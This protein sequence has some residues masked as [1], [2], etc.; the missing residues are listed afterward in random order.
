MQAVDF[1]KK[2]KDVL[3]DSSAMKNAPWKLTALTT[4]KALKA[5]KEPVG[6]ANDA[7]MSATV[8]QSDSRSKPPPP[9]K[10]EDGQ[11]LL[12]S[13]RSPITWENAHHHCTG[14]KIKVYPPR[15][16]FFDPP[17]CRAHML[18]AMMFL[19]PASQFPHLC[20]WLP[21]P[22][23][24]TP[25]SSKGFNPEPRIVLDVDDWFIL[26]SH[27]AV[28]P[29]HKVF[30]A[31]DPEVYRKLHPALQAEYGLVL[32]KGIAVTTRYV[33]WCVCVCLF[34]CFCVCA[35]PFSVSLR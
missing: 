2:V 20:A 35:P 1:S 21:C 3:F 29:N 13:E 17:D 34:V 22:H 27:S 8:R 10:V 18:K 15:Y 30:S 5:T 31:T 26:W 12:H 7:L 32:T 28:C 25:T 4:S 24:D 9:S 33:G 16:L 23:C 11:R 19:H 6:N 14:D